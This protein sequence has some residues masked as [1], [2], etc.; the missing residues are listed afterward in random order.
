MSPFQLNISFFR[1]AIHT[2][3]LLIAR[4]LKSARKKRI[5]FMGITEEQQRTLR[6]CVRESL[7]FFLIIVRFECLTLIA[8]KNPFHLRV[9]NSQ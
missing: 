8:Y 6:K 2:Y 9:V 3:L 4:Q 5:S 1:A 7:T